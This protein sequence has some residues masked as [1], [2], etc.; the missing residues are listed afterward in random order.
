M[1]YSILL[2]LAG[3]LIEPARAERWEYIS[4]VNRQIPDFDS[5]GVTDTIF[6][7]VHATIEDVNIFV[8]IGE[9]GGP[10]AEEVWIDVF[11]PDGIRVRLNDWGG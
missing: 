4:E 8:G 6:F 2:L 7:P 11:S 3:L 9:P 10:W 1:R 5:V